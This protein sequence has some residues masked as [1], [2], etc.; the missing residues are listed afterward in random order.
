MYARRRSVY[1]DMQRVTTRGDVQGRARRM[2]RGMRRDR[3]V[4]C[5][6]R[7]EL[8][9]WFKDHGLALSKQQLDAVVYATPA[10]APAPV[11]VAGTHTCT[12]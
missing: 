9:R 7:A 8:A 6:E 12:H 1:I 2:R 5:A 4:Y 3:I 11:P 10:P